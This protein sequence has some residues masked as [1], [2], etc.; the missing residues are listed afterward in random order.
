MK[1]YIL[2]Q[3]DGEIEQNA[4]ELIGASTKRD[5]DTKIG[6]FGSGLKY[7]I[8]FMMRKNIDFRIFSGN[9]EL[10]F[11]IEKDTLGNQEFERITINGKQT[12]YTTTMG[13][14]WEKHW[15]V[16]REIYCNALDEG[17]CQMVKS[18]EIVNSCEGKTRIYIELVPI[19]EE[20]VSNWDSYFSEDR[21]P[22]FSLSGIYTSYMS[23]KGSYGNLSVFR[24]TFGIVY[25]KGI[26]VYENKEL[27]FDYDFDNVD[28]NEDRTIKHSGALQYPICEIMYSFPSKDYIARVLNNT[29]SY[30]FKSLSNGNQCKVSRDWIAFSSENLLVIYE[31]SGKYTDIIK[32]TNKETYLIPYSFGSCLIEAIPEIKILGISKM[33]DGIPLDEQEETPKIKFLLKSVKEDL[34]QMNYFVNYNI[35]ICTFAIDSILGHADIKNQHIYL[36]VKL[37][38]LGKREIALTLMEENEHIISGFKD[39]TRN[40][41]SHLFTRWL[42]FMENSNGLFL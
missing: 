22:L 14:T 8:A 29:D 9:K 2:I 17:T 3:N 32:S 30:E 13:P 28:V 12:S 21:T 39:K 33:S 23:T 16:L 6:F 18:T 5:D 37:F 35:S 20:V 42:S 26:N 27:L 31:Q 25:R 38:D 40:F 11:G 19:L 10:V 7:S 34:A 15:F 24:K 1:K 36:S 4:F 41:Q